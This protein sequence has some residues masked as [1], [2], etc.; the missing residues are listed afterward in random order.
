MA[1][2]IL[3]L[4]D[5][6]HKLGSVVAAAQAGGAHV[7]RIMHGMKTIAC[8]VAD[9]AVMER[10]R[11]MDGVTSVREE[12]IFSVPPLDRDIPL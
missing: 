6:Q 10:V 5:N 3:I 9:D 8:T 1:K 2:H 7:D 11:R 12:D 4:V